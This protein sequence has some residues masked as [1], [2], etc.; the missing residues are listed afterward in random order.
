M[1]MNSTTIIR[2]IEAFGEQWLHTLKETESA[3]KSK[4]FDMA[5]DH[6]T[7]NGAKDRGNYVNR[8]GY[9][10]LRNAVESILHD[11]GMTRRL[12]HST[13]EKFVTKEFFEEIS[14]LENG[15][16]KFSVAAVIH[17][18][19]S[20]VISI[21]WADGSY[22][23]P[24]L[25]APYA[26]NSDFRMG[27]ARIVSKDI[28]LREHE[29]N[30][31]KERAESKKSSVEFLKEW[32]S[33]VERYDHFIIIEIC[34]FELD[35][36]WDIGR[37]VAEFCLNLIRMVFGYYHTRHIKLSGGFIWDEL[38]TKLMISKDGNAGFSSSRGPWGSH[39]NDDWIDMFNNRLSPMSGTLAS[40]CALLASGE[41]VGTPIL[42]RQRYAHQLIAEAYC[43]P[44]DHIRLVRLISALEAFAV[45]E[46]NDKAETLAVNCSQ[47]GGFSQTN[48]AMEIHAGVMNAYK[49][50]NK[51]VHGDGASPDEISGAFFGIEHHLLDIVEGYTILYVGIW[52]IAN[53]KHVN[54][55]R[56]ELKKRI[57]MFFWNSEL[58]LSK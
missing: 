53:P 58:A 17:R 27:P 52:N 10:H 36:A 34:G 45:I 43:E 3:I 44:H 56:R 15:K 18:A 14:R 13:M 54:H 8:Q 23:F 47:A 50:R 48:T 12:S 46:K 37:E 39:L 42:E 4:N 29:R 24:V 28:F 49:V 19:K 9:R 16:K 2:E 1:S 26:K 51:I 33:Y 57:T 41:Y 21:K 11:L 6:V 32:D 35:L 20:H 55:L 7:L 30:L 5:S 38:A 31:T 40:L 25:F 22:V